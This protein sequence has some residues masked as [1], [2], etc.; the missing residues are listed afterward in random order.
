[1][2]IIEKEVW[3]KDMDNASSISE[4]LETLKRLH[5]NGIY[6][7]LFMLPMFP[8]ITDFRKIIESSRE[9]VEEYWFENL[10]L[11]GSYK[12]D[13]LS[14]IEKAYPQFVD[15]YTEIYKKGNMEY[16]H[17]CAH[18]ASLLCEQLMHQCLRCSQRK[19][20]E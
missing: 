9:F 8:G 7:I 14:Y 4:R 5:E 18:A 6:T 13:I 10:N 12:Q 16:W 3:V 2:K 17:N 19:L 1:M 15:L 11:R 20:G